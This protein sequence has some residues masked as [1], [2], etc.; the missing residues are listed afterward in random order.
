ME[1]SAQIRAFLTSHRQEMVE[2]T[3]TLVRAQ[4][5][6]ADRAACEACADAVEALVRARLGLSP[7]AVYPQ[8]HN[9]RHLYY[10]VGEGRRAGL[11]IGHYDTVWNIDAL[12]LSVTD[13]RIA[14]PGAYDMKYG[15]VAAVWSLL[16]LRELGLQTCAYGLFLNS[17]EETGSESSRPIFEP[18]AREWEN[19]LILEPATGSSIKSGRKG[20][21]SFNI[22]VHGVAAHAGNDYEKGRSAILEAAKLVQKLHGLT[23]LSRGTTVNVGL[24][25]G[26]SKRN[27]VAAQAELRVDF[28]V[29]NAEEAARILREVRALTPSADG[30]RFDISGELNRPPFEFTQA[31]QALYQRIE[32][33]GREMGLP[34]SH[35]FVGG[36]SDGNFTSAM[37][38]P[39]LDGFGAV[40]AG[41]HADYE[42]ILID[43][44]IQHTGLLCASLLQL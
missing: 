42:H 4:S 36:G 39:T 18:I 6:T 19:V 1:R 37:G 31:N 8:E 11:L 26:G 9:G 40:G 2:D 23:D 7:T 13:N 32:A 21:G 12:P 29:C 17:D 43:E 15:I 24:I 27:V 14:G 41:A 25:S 16:A 28:R 35:V 20:V 10:V 30:V 33:A 22:T 38:I 5:P 3:L 44:S 34:V